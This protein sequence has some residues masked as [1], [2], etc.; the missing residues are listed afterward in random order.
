[1]NID[2]DISKA[3]PNNTT[4]GWVT[5]LIQIPILMV[6]P[7]HSIIAGNTTAFF[8]KLTVGSDNL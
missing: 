7:I 6:N 8:Y 4:E 2:A 5:S 1:M 3:V